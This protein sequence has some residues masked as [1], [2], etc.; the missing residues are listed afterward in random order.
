M[1]TVLILEDDPD[2]AELYRRSLADAGHRV[3]GVEGHPRDVLGR[4]EAPDLII[5][6]ERLGAISGLRALP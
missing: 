2:L 3:V 6:D 5:L 4:P 1:A